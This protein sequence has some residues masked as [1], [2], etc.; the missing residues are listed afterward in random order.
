MDCGFSFIKLKFVPD[1][2][3]GTFQNFDDP[4]ANWTQSISPQVLLHYISMTPFLGRNS[5][6]FYRCSVK[7]SLP[8]SFEFRALKVSNSVLE[9][10]FR[11][12]QASK[13][14]VISPLPST[15]NDSSHQDK[16]LWF[17]DARIWWTVQGNWPSRLYVWASEL[18]FS[19]L[20]S[21]LFEKCLQSKLVAWL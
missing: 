2:V 1:F 11:S 20:I 7:Y 6:P 12:L 15:W 5:I 9:V 3:V 19:L 21:D 4:P 13:F 17:V 14:S 10:T 16:T 18:V 8:F